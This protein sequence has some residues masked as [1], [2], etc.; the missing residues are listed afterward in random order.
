MIGQSTLFGRRDRQPGPGE[1]LWNDGWDGYDASRR[2]VYNHAGACGRRLR[3]LLRNIAAAD[4]KSGAREDEVVWH[5]RAG[6][7]E[8]VTPGGATR[9]AAPPL[10]ERA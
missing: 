1:L 7:A 5:N 8:Y 4:K 6:L 9:A 10:Y 3:P 2:R